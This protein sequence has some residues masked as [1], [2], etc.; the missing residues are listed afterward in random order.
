MPTLEFHAHDVPDGGMHTFEIGDQKV[1]VTRDGDECRAYDAL[2]PHAGANLGEGLRCG[3]RVICPWHHA[4]FEASSGEL[5]EPPALHGLTRY[6][7]SRDG[8]TWRVDLNEEVAPDS[9]PE[10]GKGKHTVIVG[11]GAAG[12]MA[13]QTLRT[14]GYAGRITVL[15]AENRAPYDRTALSKA[16]LSGKKPEEKLPLGGPDWARQ[17]DIEVREGVRVEALD[18]DAHTVRLAGKETLNYD[19]LI[20]AT[21]ATPNTLKVPG[22]ELAGIYQLR[23]LEDAESLKEAAA[24]KHLVIVGSSFIG[25]EAASSLVD[26]AASVTVIGQEAEIM[27]RAVTPTVGQAIRALHQQHGVK[28]YLSAEV[29]SFEGSGQAEAVKLKSGERI[30]ADLVLLGVGVQPNSDLLSELANDKGAVPVDENMRAAPDVYAVGDIALA[31]NVLGEMRVEHWRVALQGGMVAA[32]DI[33]KQP[34]PMSGRVP[35]FWTQQYGKS[36]RYVGH[37]GSLDDTHLW[38]DPAELKFIEFTF[39]DGRAVAASGMGQDKELIAFEEL[40]RQQRAPSA[41]ELRA[42]VFSLAGRLGEQSGP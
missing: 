25:L 23:S 19:A 14:G 5:I 13:A 20:V 11:G 16:Y 39:N 1:L 3:V 31:P 42:G 4:T 8:D 37:A 38:G 32:Q 26:S 35:F 2:C 40:L 9:P 28:F 24:G 29:E 12:F 36:L 33:L 27:S 15:S 21:G 22:A 17:H 10:S 41:D 18:R 30:R 7:L 34:A 6:K